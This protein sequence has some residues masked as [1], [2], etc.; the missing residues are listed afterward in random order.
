[1][2]SK[3]ASFLNMDFKYND[4]DINEKVIETVS[5]VLLVQVRTFIDLP[6]N[7]FVVKLHIEYYILSKSQNR[8]YTTSGMKVKTHV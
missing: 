5:T 7:V 3:H 1:M 4:E 2:C 8:A 6:E